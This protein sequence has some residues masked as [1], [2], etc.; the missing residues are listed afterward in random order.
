MWEIRFDTEM[1]GPWHYSLCSAQTE[2]H[3]MA[4]APSQ[5]LF[6]QG[7]PQGH[8]VCVS[9]LHGSVGGREW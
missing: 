1:S 6:V 8:A 9:L 3:P 4:P 7:T 5:G 2:H